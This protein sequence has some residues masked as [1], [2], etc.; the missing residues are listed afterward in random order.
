M[1]RRINGIR[2]EAEARLFVSVISGN[3]TQSML[4]KKT[5]SEILNLSL[6]R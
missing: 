5:Y 6:S 2:L 4:L 3:P 1:E